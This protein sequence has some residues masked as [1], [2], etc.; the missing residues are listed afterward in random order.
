MG[1]AYI[2]EVDRMLDNLFIE[3]R[4]QKQKEREED[5]SGLEAELMKKMIRLIEIKKQLGGIP[6]VFHDSE[7]L[8]EEMILSYDLGFYIP[9]PP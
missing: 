2:E 8:L 6:E 5:K 1:L 9:S 4:E 3:K 7:L